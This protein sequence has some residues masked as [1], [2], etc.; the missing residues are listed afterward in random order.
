MIAFDVSVNG[1]HL[2]RAGVGDQ[3]VLSAIVNYVNR[4]NGDSPAEAQGNRDAEIDLSVGGLIQPGGEYVRWLDQELKLGDVI[5]VKVS[6]ERAV[7]EPVARYAS[8][9]SP[10]Q[11]T[12][13]G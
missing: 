3:G 5:L 4:A 6:E 1:R 7:D 8:T 12:S 10:C 9:C 2:C 13:S 11:T